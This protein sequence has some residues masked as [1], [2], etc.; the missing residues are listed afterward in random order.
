MPMS[1]ETAKISPFGQ[2]TQPY[3]D[4][5]HSL[6]SRFDEGIQID[7]E[8]L[9]SA[10]PENTA[11][12]IG[13]RTRGDTVLDAFCGVGGSA[14]G[15]ARAGRKVI[16]V[17]S[18]PRRLDLARHNARIYG[19]E[20]SITFVHSDIVEFLRSDPQIYDSIY[21][22]PPWGGPDYYRREFFTLSM[23]SPDGNELMKAT[24]G[25]C[26][27]LIMTVPNNF[28]LRELKACQRDFSLEWNAEGR[29]RL[30]ATVYFD[31][32]AIE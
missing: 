9:Y 3:W 11:L 25:R 18:D 26:R 1:N 32:A 6:F 21:L 13:G 14:I 4:R 15:F 10:K 31:R 30:F 19:V 23:F 7:R 27:Q 8:G 12:H 2:D 29:R 22:D 16:S 28:D 20:A 24:D 5:R 17:D